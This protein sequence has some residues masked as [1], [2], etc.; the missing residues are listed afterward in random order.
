MFS[1]EA[2]P[3]GGRPSGGLEIYCSPF[4]KGILLSKTA[5]HVCVKLRKFIVISIYYKPSLEFDDKI[6][7][8]IIALSACE[9]YCDVP[10]VVGGDLNIH[11]GSFDFSNLSDIMSRF[12]LEL[13]S[14]PNIPTFLGN[15]G[16]PTTPDHIFCSSSLLVTQFSVPSKIESDHQ[17]LTVKI[18]IC[19]DDSPPVPR[20]A[21]N[22]ELCTEELHNL[23]VSQA[24]NL[25]TVDLAKKI[26]KILLN[27]QQDLPPKV[28]TNFKIKEMKDEVLNAFKLYQRYKSQF[29]KTI[30][31][32]FIA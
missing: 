28:N 29:F 2:V 1:A 25:T 5:S 6:S 3:T 23:R 17:P 21:I 18:G 4:D 15:T 11:Y 10:I 14:N 31:I 32:F 19:K 26:T 20:K 12:N 24:N 22:F 8:L 7:D 30:Y 9:K 27:C 13:C 16:N